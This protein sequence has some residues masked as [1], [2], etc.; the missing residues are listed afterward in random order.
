MEGSIKDLSQYR[1][2]CAKENFGGIKSI[3]TGWP[4]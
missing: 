4:V 3:D 2:S 1:F